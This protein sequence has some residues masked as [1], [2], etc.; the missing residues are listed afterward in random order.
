MRNNCYAEMFYYRIE[1]QMDNQLF[2]KFSIAILCDWKFDYQLMDGWLMQVSDGIIAPGYDEDAL[3]I[4]RRKK[5]GAY[6]VIKA[7]AFVIG[8]CL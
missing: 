5:N 1:L 8:G 3:E 4:L 2:N 6:C 7:N